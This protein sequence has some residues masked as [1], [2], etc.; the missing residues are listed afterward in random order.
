MSRICN[1]KNDGSDARRPLLHF[2]LA[3]FEAGDLRG[4]RWRVPV[5][6]SAKQVRYASF[7][8]I[9]DYAWMAPCFRYR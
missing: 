6:Q 3:F 1:L 5:R 2:R 8:E 4:Y 7:E 9:S